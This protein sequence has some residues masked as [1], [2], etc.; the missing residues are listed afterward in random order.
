MNTIKVKNFQLYLLLCII[1]FGCEKNSNGLFV[2][3]AI[4]F[5]NATIITANQ[6]GNI[7]NAKKHLVIQND[8]IIYVGEKAPKLQGAHEVI[9][10]S[11]KYII[12]GLIDGHVHLANIAGFNYQQKQKYPKLVNAYYQQLPKSFLYFGFTTLIDLNNYAPNVINRINEAE[13]K[14]DIYTCG[15][16]VQVM[17]DFMMEM[18]ELPKEL[19]YKTSFLHDRY[20]KNVSFP[21]SI[22]LEPN[23]ARKVIKRIADQENGICVKTLYE[24]ETT[25]FR[26]FWES[27]TKEIMRELIHEAHNENIPVLLHATSF[28]GQSFAVDTGIDIIA[29]GMW[30]W[31]DNPTELANTTLPKPHYELLKK[32]ANKKIGYQPTFRALFAEDDVISEKLLYDREMENVL[33]TVFLDWL[34]TEES[35]WTK[36]KLLYRINFI[37]KVNP[38]FYEKARANFESDREMRIVLTKSVRERLDIVVKFLYENNANLLFATDGVAMGMYANPPGYNGYL[39]L[40]HWKEAGVSLDVVFRALTIN[41]AEAFNLDGEIGTIEKGKKANLLLLNKNPLVD[42]SAYNSIESVIINGKLIKRLSL[43]AKQS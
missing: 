10:S 26:K 7:T 29:H 16:Q 35:Q 37:R 2:E 33:P 38:T 34:K 19:R 42:V 13:I 39:E 41:N 14:P 21:D 4:H 17:N 18:E 31:T 28:E 25:G 1:C 20:N 32:I 40:N 15:Q 5:K 36:H 6:T 8:S 12:P 24:D 11:G 22:N 30:N 3:N 27:P 9:E 43:S 23:S